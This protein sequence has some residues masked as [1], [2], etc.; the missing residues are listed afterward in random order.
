MIQPSDIQSVPR[1]HRS[2]ARRSTELRSGTAATEL[3]MVAPFLVLILMAAIDVGQAINVAQIVN[4]ACREGARCST[5]ADVDDAMEVEEAVQ[6]YFSRAFPGAGS[7]LY[8]AVSVTV[9][10]SVGSVPGGDLS[11][12]DS[13]DPVG[14]QVSLQYD[15]VRWTSWFAWLSGTT[16]ETSTV[17]RRE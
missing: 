3:A 14:V 16:L 6:E 5:R 11:S 1:R 7:A 8:D 13:G 15:S 10:D 9:S 12:I 4:D 17:M 2:R